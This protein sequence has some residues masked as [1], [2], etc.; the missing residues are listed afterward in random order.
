MS[1]DISKGSD[2]TLALMQRIMSELKNTI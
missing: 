2:Y 1:F